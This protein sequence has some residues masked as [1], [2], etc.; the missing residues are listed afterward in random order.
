MLSPD[1]TASASKQSSQLDEGGTDTHPAGPY[2]RLW[3]QEVPSEM[4]H[5]MMSFQRWGDRDLELGVNY[6]KAPGRCRTT[7]R[8]QVS[9]ALG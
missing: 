5:P 1:V 8:T 9:Q 2:F 3:G 6:L 4:V 7:T